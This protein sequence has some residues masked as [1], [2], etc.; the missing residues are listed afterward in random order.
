MNIIYPLKRVSYKLV[1]FTDY[2]SE[3]FS[4]FLSLRSKLSTKD[5]TQSTPRC[6]HI[7]DRIR[8]VSINPPQY[9]KRGRRVTPIMTVMYR[10][11]YQG[12]VYRGVAGPRRKQQG[13]IVDGRGCDKL[14]VHAE[15][16][17]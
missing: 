10:A 11:I 13:G 15:G 17:L 16:E 7:K 5:S 14:S 2:S 9:D 8:R 1:T 12:K 4:H 6:K 3:L